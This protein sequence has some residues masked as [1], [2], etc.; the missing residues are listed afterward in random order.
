MWI[1]LLRK[2]HTFLEGISSFTSTITTS[3]HSSSFSC[4]QCLWPAFFIA[5][6]C[7]CTAVCFSSKNISSCCLHTAAAWGTFTALAEEEATC[8]IFFRSLLSRERS[9]R[10]ELELPLKSGFSPPSSPA[11]EMSR[12]LSSATLCP[13]CLHAP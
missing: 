5:S 1:G 10:P 13:A 9:S 7:C 6:R 4:C 8:L 11:P 2:N 12:K 3:L